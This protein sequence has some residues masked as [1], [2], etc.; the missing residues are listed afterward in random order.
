MLQTDTVA[1]QHHLGPPAFRRARGNKLA[2]CLLVPIPDSQWRTRGWTF[3]QQSVISCP[4][5]P[6][7]SSPAPWAPVAW[8]A[9]ASGKAAPQTTSKALRLVLFWLNTVH[10]RGASGGCFSGR[11]TPFGERL[12]VKDAIQEA[13]QLFAFTLPQKQVGAWEETSSTSTAEASAP[14]QTVHIRG[15]E[16]P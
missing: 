9:P 1:A 2:L 4:R 11:G 5:A 6:R 7:T 13:T 10:G 12:G 16:E 8:I 14:S 3:L 15:K